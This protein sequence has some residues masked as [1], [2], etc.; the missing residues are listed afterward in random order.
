[1]FYTKRSWLSRLP[2]ITD[3]DDENRTGEVPISQLCGLSDGRDRHFAMDFLILQVSV[4]Q[5]IRTLYLRGAFWVI[6]LF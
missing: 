4:H 1:M 6:A 5:P 3:K 2:A